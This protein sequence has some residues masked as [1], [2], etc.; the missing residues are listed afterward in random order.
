MK[1]TIGGTEL[2][3]GG[4]YLTELRSSNDVMHDAE[5]L[6]ERMREDG[7]VL[8]RGFHDREKVLR[9]RAEIVNKL[10]ALGKLDP[11][12][13]LDEARIREG[14]KGVMF[15]GTN[16]DSPA[17]LDVVNAP[18]VLDF[19][20]AF[21]G[22]PAMTY[23]Y[24]WLRAVA[25]GGFTGAHYDIVYMGRGTKN[26]FTLWTPIGDT[27]VEMGT[28]AVLLGSH[29]LERVKETYGRMDVDRD[30]TDG[31]FSRDPLEIAEKFGGR[32]ATADFRAGDAIFFGMYLMHA[33]TDNKTNRYRLSCDT[34]Y[35]LASE[36]VDDRWIGAK[37]KGHTGADGGERVSMEEARRRWGLA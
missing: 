31:W 23:D 15:G 9:A 26:V 4:P 17:Y 7:Y 18:E 22:G 20:S 10:H 13:P 36:P 16:D 33:S 1:V 34:R 25:T 29:K 5:A 28:L 21:L 32:W 11:A 24:K 6:R 35:Q 3:M 12:A 19:F 27:P 8:I 37:P 30:R 2:E 14:G